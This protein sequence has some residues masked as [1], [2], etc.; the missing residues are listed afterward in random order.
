M[1]RTDAEISFVLDQVAKR[2][3]DIDHGVVILSSC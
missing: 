1:S 2:L 3:V